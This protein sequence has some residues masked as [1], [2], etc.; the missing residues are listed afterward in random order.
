MESCEPMQTVFWSQ[1]NYIWNQQKR[2]LETFKN[3]EIKQQILNNLRVNEEISREIWKY[4]ELNENEHTTYQNVQNEAKAVLRGNFIDLNAYIY[5]KNL[6]SNLK[7]H[8]KKTFLFSDLT[9]KVFDY[10]YD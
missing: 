3:V 2:R 4:F 7:K 8:D 6:T 5:K 1:Q 10:F 9:V